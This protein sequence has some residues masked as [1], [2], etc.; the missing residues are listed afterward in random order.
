MGFRAATFCN[1]K[2]GNQEFKKVAR[3]TTDVNIL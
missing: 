1:L 2:R 3:K